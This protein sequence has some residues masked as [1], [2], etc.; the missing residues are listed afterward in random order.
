MS[1]TNISRLPRYYAI[2]AACW[3]FVDAFIRGSDDRYTREIVS[4]HVKI[5]LDESF[6]HIVTRVNGHAAF[7]IVRVNFEH[8][9]GKF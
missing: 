4:K 3:G 2:P 1:I 7:L 6:I 5:R 8:E 9:E